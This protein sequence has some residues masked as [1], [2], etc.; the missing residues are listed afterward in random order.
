MDRI[1]FLK[2]ISY[3]FNYEYAYDEGYARFIVKGDVAEKI[4][5][6]IKENGDESNEIKSFLLELEE[7]QEF[8]SLKELSLAMDK[9]ISVFI[10]AEYDHYSMEDYSELAYM[11]KFDP[12]TLFDALHSDENEEV[13]VYRLE[14]KEGKGIYTIGLKDT[15][16]V[17]RDQPPPFEDGDIKAIFTP[18]KAGF[19]TDYNQRWFFGFKDI[20]DLE[21]WFNSEIDLFL[22]MISIYKVPKR[23][24]V[25]GKKQLIFK[26]EQSEFKEFYI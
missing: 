8:L 9:L 15:R 14:N 23:F 17:S 21:K 16:V 22:D 5:D 6:L 4:Y 25:Y 13:L 7:I 1:R 2:D 3:H 19:K 24:V 26:K 10:V 20:E 12:N 18:E 11:I